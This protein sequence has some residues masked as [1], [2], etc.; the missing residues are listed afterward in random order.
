LLA[1]YLLPSIIAR[2]NRL[3]SSV[4]VINVL[5]GWTVIGWLIALGIALS[6]MYEMP[7][8]KCAAFIDKKARVCRYC[9]YDLGRENSRELANKPANDGA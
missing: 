4:Y 3:R 7:C 1:I 2:V 6:E 9:G 8:P 5:F